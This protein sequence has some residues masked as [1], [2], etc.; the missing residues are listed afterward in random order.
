MV[1]TWILTSGSSTAEE[2][3]IH[4]AKPREIA[5]KGFVNDY[6]AHGI[7][8]KLTLVNDEW[9]EFKMTNDSNE[10]VDN[11]MYMLPT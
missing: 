6:L 9:V 11:I 1:G 5:W 10:Q 3:S 7:V 8:E 2:A 4:A